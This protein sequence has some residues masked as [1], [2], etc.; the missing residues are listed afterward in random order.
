MSHFLL[1]KVLLPPSII[2]DLSSN[3]Q[4]IAVFTAATGK[5]IHTRI[6]TIAARSE[7]PEVMEELRAIT[8]ELDSLREFVSL[9]DTGQD[10]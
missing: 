10:G 1:S 4:E 8:L 3:L 9:F 5:A 6:D 7:H 2:N